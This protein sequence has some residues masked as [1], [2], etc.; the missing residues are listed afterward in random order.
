MTLLEGGDLEFYVSHSKTDQ[1]GHGFLFH[2][3]GEMHRGFSM[4]G[5]L[6]WY[7]EST[8]LSGTDFLFHR[9][10]NDGGRVVAVRDKC[11][12]YSSVALQLKDFFKKIVS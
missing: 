10:R 9:F 6:K 8:N 5:V 2:V 4:P 1:D 12:S 3:S 7:L 11:I